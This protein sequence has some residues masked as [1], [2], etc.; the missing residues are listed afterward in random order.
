MS[1]STIVRTS[2]AVEQV[3]ALDTEF[4]AAVKRNDVTVM[5]AILADAQGIAY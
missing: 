1:V 5:D 4:R 3:A 2:T